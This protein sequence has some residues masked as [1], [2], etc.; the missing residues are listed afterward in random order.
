MIKD[1]IIHYCKDPGGQSQ[2]LANTFHLIC[3]TV[4]RS[5]FTAVIIRK[6]NLGVPPTPHAPVPDY[7]LKTPKQD[8]E[9]IARKRKDIVEVSRKYVELRRRNKS[10]LG[11]N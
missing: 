10:A 9:V 4:L 2:R 5:A 3:R 8:S 1:V 11:A 6:G 7:R